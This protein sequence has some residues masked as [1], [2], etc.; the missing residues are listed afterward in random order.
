MK[1]QRNLKFWL[2]N[3]DVI[4]ASVAM[5]ALVA[6]TFGGVIA[7][8][9]LSAPFAWI[10]EVQA[11]MIVWVIFGAAGAAF[12]TANHAAIE[13]FYE[14][15]PK[16]AKTVINILILIV[17][18]FTLAFLGYLSIQYMNVFAASGRTTAILHL[19]YIA[20]YCIV[21]ISCVWQ[22]FNF[23]LVNFF[24]YSEQET[25]EAITDEEFEEAKKE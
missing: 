22:I 7:R 12:R 25:I 6:V 21:P 11:A 23:I 4:I 18:V 24:H 1:Q 13:V 15:F 14:F 3:I 8:Y 2:L 17:S 9:V 16:V 19:S 20:I 5:C 10:E